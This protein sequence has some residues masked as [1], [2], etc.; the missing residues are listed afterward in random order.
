MSSWMRWM[1]FVPL[2]VLLCESVVSRERRI[3][4]QCTATSTHSYVSRVR[5]Q[6]L[7]SQQWWW[8]PA[9]GDN[10]IR[11]WWVHSW[12]SSLLEIFIASFIAVSPEIFQIFQR[13]VL[14]NLMMNSKR[15]LSQSYNNIWLYSLRKVMT[16]TKIG[17]VEVPI[18]Q[19]EYSHDRSSIEKC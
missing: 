6:R 5:S 1:L 18:S 3:W 7:V 16:G 17:G 8:R 2:R 9:G 14:M 4:G 12:E 10:N 13:F 19:R 11:E 15:H